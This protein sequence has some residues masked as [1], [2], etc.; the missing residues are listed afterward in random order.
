MSLVA[1]TRLLREAR[2]ASQL[3]HPHICTFHDVGEADGQ[4]CIGTEL[5]EGQLLNARLAG[6][7]LPAE[8]LLRFRRQIA[9]A[10]AHLEEELKEA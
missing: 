4:A 9:D 3:N 5:V 8:Q 10:L 1:G 2:L 6:G 7:A